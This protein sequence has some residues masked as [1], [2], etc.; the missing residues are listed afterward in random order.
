MKMKI[1]NAHER[2]LDTTPEKVGAI[3]DTLSSK[4]DRLW[5]GDRWP[6]QRFDAPLG[7]GARGGH[8]PIRYAVSAYVPGR[9]VEYRFDGTGLTAKWD[10]RHLFE[11]I[12]RKSHVILR[13][14]I[15][16]T[17]DPRAWLT[18]F[19]MI[20]PMHNAL[21]E[22]GLDRTESGLGIGPKRPARWGV[23]VKLMRRMVAKKAARAAGK[24]AA[25]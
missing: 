13:H 3:L 22:D 24:P 2:K 20:R 12:P 10:G 9:I 17:C 7:V 23:W 4:Y 19:F 5:P 21:I 14:T 16:A 25:A 15:D 8:G 1:W 11:V 18:W 6:P